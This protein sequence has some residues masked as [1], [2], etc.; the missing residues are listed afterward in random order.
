MKE[1]RFLLY[2]IRKNIS[3][4]AELRASFLLN[5]F[6]MMLNNCSLLILWVFFM[7]TVGQVGGWGQLDVVALVGFVTLAFG[8]VFSFFNG[9]S[10]LAASV[11]SGGFDRFLVSPRRILPRVATSSFGVSA[12]GDIFYGFISLIIYSMAMKLGIEA[13][14]MLVCGV[15]I[16]CVVFFSILLLTQTA[17][18]WLMDSVSLSQSLFEVFLTPSLFVGGTFQGIN[19]LV[20]TFI[21]PSLLVGTLPVEAIK[22]M[23]WPRLALAAS[24]ATLFL[25]LSIFLFHRG[26]KKYESSNL[27]NF[28]YG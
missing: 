13:G 27:N 4:S 2:S 3:N 25:A 26:I 21:I 14:V 17:G 20:F 5:A 22:Q 1:L 8:I 28:G 23:N 9:L 12:V 15:F 19:R 7:K 24:L 16:A 6:G 10:K 11:A 18:F